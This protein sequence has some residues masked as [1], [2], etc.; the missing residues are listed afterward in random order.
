MTTTEY[1]DNVMKSVEGFLGTYPCNM[2]PKLNKRLGLNSMI[3]NLDDS[4][5][6]GSHWVGIIVENKNNTVHYYDPLGSKAS[7]K[8]ISK[9]VNKFKKIY[10]N[11]HKIQPIESVHC[12]IYCIGFILHSVKNG[13]SITSYN[14]MFCKT[15]LATIFNDDIAVWYI[16]N[17]W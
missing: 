4:Q 7:N 11:N 1:I 14:S 13:V 9:F 16:V 15:R 12:G 17:N 3:I 5:Q 2:I 8:H 10:Y 6:S